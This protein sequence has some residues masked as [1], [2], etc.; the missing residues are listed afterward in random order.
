MKI[1]PVGGLGKYFMNHVLDCSPVLG[2]NCPDFECFPPN[3]TAVL[4]G[5]PVGVV[6]MVVLRIKYEAGHHPSHRT[7]STPDGLR[8]FQG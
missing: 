5:L 8:V 2:S 6:G 7:P 1:Y 4:R 3:R